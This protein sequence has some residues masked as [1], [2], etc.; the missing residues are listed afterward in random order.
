MEPQ[1]KDSTEPVDLYAR[2]EDFKIS[3]EEL[4]EK[5]ELALTHSEEYGDNEEGAWFEIH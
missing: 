4:V 2:I 1:K 5:L 3:L